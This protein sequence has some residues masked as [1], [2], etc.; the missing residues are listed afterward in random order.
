MDLNVKEDK[1]KL[2]TIPIKFYSL[3]DEYVKS[4]SLVE[5]RNHTLIHSIIR[6]IYKS[7]SYITKDLLKNGNK[8]FLN[9]NGIEQHSSKWIY[10]LFDFIDGKHKD[11]FNFNGKDK[12]GLTPLHLATM[13]RL[14]PIIEKLLELGVQINE[15]SSTYSFTA[16][17]IAASNADLNTIQLLISWKVNVFALDSYHRTACQIAKSQHFLEVVEFFQNLGN[18]IENSCNNDPQN[19]VESCSFDHNL[20]NNIKNQDTLIK[21]HSS[22]ILGLFFFKKKNTLFV[23]KKRKEIQNQRK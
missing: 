11:S 1:E 13:F 3:V 20:G 2:E 15:E 4:I 12:K 8:E 14:Q 21:I 23:S 5:E 6:G 18:G 17:H 19:Q 22:P 7:K 9:Y 16:L 10:T